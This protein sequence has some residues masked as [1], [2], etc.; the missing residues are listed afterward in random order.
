MKHKIKIKEVNLTERHIKQLP[1]EHYWKGEFDFSTAE[2]HGVEQEAGFIIATD[3]EG[4]VHRISPIAYLEYLVGHG[5]G[6]G[7]SQL[8]M[9]EAMEKKDKLP[10]LFAR[11]ASA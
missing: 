9:A 5:A 6:K 11:D 3:N 4:H 7:K 10:P 8:T 2:I 1:Y